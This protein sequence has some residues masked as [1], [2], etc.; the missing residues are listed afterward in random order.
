M[1]GRMKKY[2]FDEKSWSTRE[3]ECGGCDRMWG[4]GDVE[5]WGELNTRSPKVLV[6][7]GGHGVP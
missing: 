2:Y 6:V 5:M 4:C 3:I 1:P 7:G